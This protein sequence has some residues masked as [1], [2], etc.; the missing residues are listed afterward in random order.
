MR[1]DVEEVDMPGYEGL[2]DDRRSM[3]MWEKGDLVERCGYGGLVSIFMCM[4]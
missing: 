3:M 4:C 1:V 2:L